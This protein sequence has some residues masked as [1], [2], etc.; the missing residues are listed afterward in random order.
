MRGFFAIPFA[1]LIKTKWFGE[2]HGYATTTQSLLYTKKINVRTQEFN[3]EARA[4]FPNHLFSTYSFWFSSRLTPVWQKFLSAFIACCLIHNSPSLPPT[5]HNCVALVWSYG[6]LQ[7]FADHWT[8]CSGYLPFHVRSLGR[9]SCTTELAAGMGSLSMFAALKE[10]FPRRWHYERGV[11]EHL[12]EGTKTPLPCSSLKK[13]WVTL[14]ARKFTQ[15]GE[16]G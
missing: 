14:C 6:F 9:L 12:P 15:D 1:R 11:E 8:T 2:L 10:P 4:W 16:M 7:R 5:Y 3:L 13:S